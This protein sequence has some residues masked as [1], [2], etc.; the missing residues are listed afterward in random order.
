MVIFYITTGK[1][2]TTSYIQA[3]CMLELINTEV[4]DEENTNEKAMVVV[5]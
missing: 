3:F 1:N 5:C 2:Q 4:N